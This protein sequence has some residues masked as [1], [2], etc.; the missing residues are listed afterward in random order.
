MATPSIPV[1]SGGHFV[2][3]FGWCLGF[4]VFFGHFGS[5]CGEKLCRP[6]PR[7]VIPS[8]AR[9]CRLQ[10]LVA[11]TIGPSLPPCPRR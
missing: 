1:G 4:V 5:T 6:P 10:M 11:L 9:Y 2:A 8:V 3:R 7:Q